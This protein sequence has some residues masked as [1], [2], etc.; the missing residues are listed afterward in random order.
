MYLLAVTGFLVTVISGLYSQDLCPNS[1]TLSSVCLPAGKPLGS[2]GER[3][4]AGPAEAMPVYN[5]AGT[6]EP[7][8]LIRV[9]LI[10]A[11]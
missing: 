4:P 11:S 6:A 10:V 3:A 1:L 8:R 2:T 5:W 7:G 9:L